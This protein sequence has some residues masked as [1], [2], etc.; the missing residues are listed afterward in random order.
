[1]VCLFSTY[2]YKT[3]DFRSMLFLCLCMQIFFNKCQLCWFMILAPS[4]I[5]IFLS[6]CL[7]H[8]FPTQKKVREFLYSL[9]KGCCLFFLCISV[10]KA[11]NMEDLYFNHIQNRVYLLY[12]NVISQKI[13]SRSWWY[14]SLLVSSANV[15]CL[16]AYRL[17]RLQI[18]LLIS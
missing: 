1:M 7:H 13:F 16:C 6:F 4:I 11:K 15:E 8:E 9:A 14:F 2:Q 12:C 10:L 17:W 5:N 18:Y 3:F